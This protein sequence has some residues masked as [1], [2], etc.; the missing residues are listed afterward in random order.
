MVS[1]TLTLVLVRRRQAAIQEGLEQA[2]GVPLTLAQR[3]N[4]LWP[5]LKEMVT[6]GNIACKSDAQ[7]RYQ[8]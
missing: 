6:Y 5:H 3:V 8:G 2:V 4:V 1:R 7:V